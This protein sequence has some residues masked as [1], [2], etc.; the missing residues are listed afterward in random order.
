M[1]ALSNLNHTP[2]TLPQS[3][4]QPLPASILT[5]SGSLQPLAEAF[6]SFLEGQKNL[7]ASSIANYLS[8]VNRFLTWLSQSLQ[9]KIIN[10][11]HI[12]AAVCLAYQQFLQNSYPAA[13]ANRHLS[14]L[15]RFGE[16]LAATGRAEADPTD[17]LSSV[18]ATKVKD[19][20]GLYKNYLENQ[21]LS[22]STIKNYLSDIKSYLLWAQKQA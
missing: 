2:K 1:S 20:M 13:T 8:D 4:S 9:E 10:A 12:T 18:P 7:S 3:L 11:G 19:I 14:S 17:K 5:L 16:F 6:K 21:S 22:P 15:K